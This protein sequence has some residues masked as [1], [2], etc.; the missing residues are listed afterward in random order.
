MSSPARP[1]PPEPLPP[2]DLRL[3]APESRYEIDDGRLVYV[4]PSDE[5]H[6]T[7]HSKATALVEAHAHPDY[8]VACDMLTRLSETSDQAPDVSVFPRERDPET[9]GRRIEELAIEI[10]STE[11]LSNAGR[12]AQKLVA[13]G[14]RRV[15][16]IDVQR[17]RAF[18]WSRDLGTWQILAA[19]ASV[20]DPTLAVP[21]PIDA[22]VRAA[23][24]DDA[25]ARALLA[26]KNP[27]LV[28]ALADSEARGEARGELRAVAEAVL[29]VL[30]ARKL[31]VSPDERARILAAQE[32]DKLRKWLELAVTCR[33]VGELLD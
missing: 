15:F 28:A 7:R 20:E 2:V 3:V 21:L 16:A 26:K 22:L 12:K 32:P 18:E 9:G 8:D 5:P 30:A 31:E 24:A 1:S 14:V 29:T 19:D 11:R 10:V 4:S 33:S 13:R 27:V 23:K 6:G 17:Q 25:V